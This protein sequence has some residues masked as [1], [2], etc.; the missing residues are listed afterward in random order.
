MNPSVL[1]LHVFPS[2][3]WFQEFVEQDS[4][5]LEVHENWVKQSFRSRYE[6]A[7]PNGRQSLSIPTLK[8]SRTTLKDVQISYS[9]DWVTNHLRSIKTAYNRSPFYEFYAHGFENILQQKP[10]FLIDLN[11]KSIEFG[12][13]Y[14]QLDKEITCSDAYRGL[15]E[16]ERD[17]KPQVITYH[18]VFEE[19]YGFVANLSFLDLLF[20]CGP[21][22]GSYYS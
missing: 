12:V 17:N 7:G 15:D 14:L 19:K 22:S 21:S 10:K 5:L 4:V 20:N 9:E 8:K 2:V 18:Q 1:P 13:Q 11:I 3:S 6:I 16:L